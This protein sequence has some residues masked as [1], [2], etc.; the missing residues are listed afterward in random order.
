MKSMLPDLKILGSARIPGM[1][2]RAMAVALIAGAFA[3]V[4]VSTAAH[5]QGSHP[6]KTFDGVDIDGKV[7]Q[8]PAG[9]QDLLSAHWK[10]EDEDVSFDVQNKKGDKLHVDNC[11]ALFKADQAGLTQPMHGSWKIYRAWAKN[12]Y[13]VRALADAKAADQSFVDDF[14]MT[15]ENVRALP[16]DLAFMVSNDDIRHMKKI[17]KN[18]GNLGDYIGK[19]TVSRGLKTGDGPSRYSVVRDQYGGVQALR[20][21]ARGD[22]DHDGVED[23]MISTATSLTGGSYEAYGLYVVTRKKPDAPFELVQRFDVMGDDLN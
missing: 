22:F 14:A 18:G 8:S 23:L 19:A 5:A 13:A 4:S 10:V 21:V 2:G 11:T 15:E 17:R 6:V 12:C 3:F 1:P 16:V 20:L 9:W 7:S